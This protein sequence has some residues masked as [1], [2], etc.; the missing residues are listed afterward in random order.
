MVNETLQWTVIVITLCLALAASRQLSA[1]L[2]QKQTIL[3]LGGPT[4]GTTLPRSAQNELRDYFSEAG[5]S[6]VFVSESCG[7]CGQLLKDISSSLDLR[8]APLLVVRGGS[9]NFIQELKEVAAVKISPALWRSLSIQATP[10]VVQ[11]DS[12][13]VVTRSGVVNDVH[14]LV[15]E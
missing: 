10:F 8:M 13:M 4:E 1:V 15:S 11:F 9:A 3:A 5:G 2:P 6:L 7:S 12:T 14:D